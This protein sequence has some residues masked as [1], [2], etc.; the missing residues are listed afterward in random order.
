VAEQAEN[1]LERCSIAGPEKG[2]LASGPFLLRVLYEILIGDCIHRAHPR[3][4]S[5]FPSR[6]RLCS[7]ADTESINRALVVTDPAPDVG[8]ARTTASSRPFAGG[9]VNAACCPNSNLRLAN[10][11]LQLLRSCEPN[12]LDGPRDGPELFR[13]Y[14][15]CHHRLLRL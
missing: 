15:G 12:P 13:R 14:T 7:I 6:T 4:P 11:Q 8:S 9:C 2:L 5:Y 1:V 10:F 3:V